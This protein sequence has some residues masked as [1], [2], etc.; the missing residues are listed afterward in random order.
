VR[1]DEK[2]D[3]V[4]LQREL[5]D[6]LADIDGAICALDNLK[7]TV[8]NR[9]VDSFKEKIAFIVN[10][11]HQLK[12]RFERNKIARDRSIVAN[13]KKTLTLIPSIIDY[14]VNV[15]VQ[16]TV[17]QWSTALEQ[18]VHFD[19]VL[20]VNTNTTMDATFETIKQLCVG[21]LFE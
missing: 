21:D 7:I 4:I 15:G 20:P 6:I 3:A 14:A 16:S 13:T 1:N 2:C 19:A 11:Q 12:T 8:A 18:N 17:A 5:D 9:K 10:M